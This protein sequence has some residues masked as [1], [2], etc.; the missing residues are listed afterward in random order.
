MVELQI[1]EFKTLLLIIMACTVVQSLFGVGLLVFGTPALLLLG[2]P[3]QQ[4]ISLL[5]PCSMVVNLLQLG[6]NLVKANRFRSD[7][8]IYCLPLIV[9]GVG[10]SIWAQSTYNVKLWIGLLLLISGLL[11]LMPLP[12]NSLTVRRQFQLP[13]LSLIGLLHGLTNMGGG[14]LTLLVG[15]LFQTKHEIRE[16]IAFAYFFMATSQLITQLLLGRGAFG[17]TN[18]LLIV[19][20]LAVYWFLGRRAFESTSNWIYQRAISFLV[21][22]FGISLALNS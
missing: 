11:R 13:A 16:N 4:A 3:Y 18:L 7:I 6:P 20:V 21:L 1:L 2:Y 5:L 12:V 9:I 19:T 22:C 14:F 10:L 15:R 17:L 8:L